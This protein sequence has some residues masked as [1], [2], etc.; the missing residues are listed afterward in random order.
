MESRVPFLNPA[1]VLSPLGG[2]RLL[3]CVCCCV[4]LSL[5]AHD[6]GWDGA[7]GYFCMS[8]WCFCLA[9]SSLVVCFEFTRLHGC[10]RLSWENFTITFALLAAQM[11]L[12]ATVVFPVYFASD[13][14][15]QGCPSRGDYFRISATVCSAVACLAYG[16]EVHLTRARPGS[17]GGYMATAPG[18][19][20]V[21]QAY[22]SCIIFGALL[23]DSEY[24][25]YPATQWCVGVYSVCFILTVAVIGLNVAGKVPVPHC[26]M[27]RVVVLYTFLAALLYLSASIVWPIFCF[28][29]KYGSVERPAS[30]SRGHCSWDS[31]LVIAIFTYV[32]LI[33]YAADLIYS[34]KVLYIA[35]P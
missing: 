22:V 3:Q 26:P 5:V 20:K 10:L 21:V 31:Q 4:A 16:V 35:R 12:T 7:P 25:R 17:L 32:N 14:Q 27:D 8:A 33:L 18:L 6:G 13:L 29:H 19:L 28:D 24:G 9:L 1:A 34:Q 23:H 11:V 15:C 30:C 2:V